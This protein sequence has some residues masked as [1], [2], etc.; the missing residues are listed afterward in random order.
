MDTSSHDLNSLLSQLGLASSPAALEA[1]LVSHRLEK[2]VALSDAPFWNKAQVQF[3]QEA[4][5]DDSDWA[6]VADELAMLLSQKS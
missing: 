2:G 1:F 4:L 3:L 5:Q 6:E